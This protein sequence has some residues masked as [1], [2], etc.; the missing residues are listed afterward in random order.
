MSYRLPEVRLPLWLGAAL[1]SLAV[2]NAARAVADNAA[3]VPMWQNVTSNIGGNEWGYAGTMCVTVAPGKDEVIVGVSAK[4]LWSTVDRGKTW[5]HLGDKDKVQ[6]NNRPYQIVFD[7]KDANTF[8]ES[9]SYGAGVFKTTDGGNS[10]QQLGSIGHVDGLAIDLDDPA[11]KT[12]LTGPHEQ[13]RSLTM[14]LD[15]GAT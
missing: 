11:R 12:L 3:A 9:G 13:G 2:L 14:S 6:I 15:G 8:W 1:C 4:G 7:P 5:V 10:F